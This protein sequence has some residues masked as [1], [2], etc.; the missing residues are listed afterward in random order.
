MN[1]QLDILEQGAA[2]LRLRQIAALESA[3]KH[4]QRLE[5]YELQHPSEAP[6]QSHCACCVQFRNDRLNEDEACG[7]CPV[8]LATG[9]AF[10]ENSPYNDAAIAWDE[11]GPKSEEFKAGAREEIQFL[12]RLLEDLKRN[13]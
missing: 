10:C 13:E 12:S 8:F 6:I 2:G 3:I 5:A 9:E 4:W 1:D 7:D 11:E